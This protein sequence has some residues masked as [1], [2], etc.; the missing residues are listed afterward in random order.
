MRKPSWP[1]VSGPL[2]CHAADYGRELS[3][4]GYSPWTAS[5]HM[6]L[7]A[8]VSRWLAE[9][10]VAP[11]AFTSARV[12]SFLADRRAAGHHRRLSGRGLIP[13][14]GYLRAT[15]VLAEQV[16]EE[17]VGSRERLLK[18]F[19]G[20]LATERGLAQRTITGYERVAGRFLVD[21][22]S[23]PSAKDCGVV[24]GTSRRG[25]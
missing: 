21:C 3:H 1:D 6:Y 2:G 13:L 4:L 24:S 16:N 5:A 10:E 8:D 19:V 18:E 12:D 11:E 23:D 17:P 25:R 9:N 14:L 22:A 7:M 20:Y 15:G